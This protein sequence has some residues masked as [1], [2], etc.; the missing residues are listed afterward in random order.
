MI[1]SRKRGS[2]W[3]AVLTLS[4][5]LAVPNLAYLQEDID[6]NSDVMKRFTTTRWSM[7]VPDK[8]YEGGCVVG[9]LAFQFSP[10]GYFVFNNRIRG[11]WRVDELGNLKLRTRD[12]ILFTML[13]DGQ[14]IR[15]TRTIGF[16]S[17]TM[18]FQRC[19]E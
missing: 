19:P 4:A 18:I 3:L 8:D 1:G 14:Q 12:G 5:A 16:L 10:T 15:S 7:I 11:S 13:V 6:P 2:G 9:F 17:R